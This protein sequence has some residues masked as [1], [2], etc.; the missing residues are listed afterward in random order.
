MCVWRVCGGCVEGECGVSVKWECGGGVW[1]E[2]GG[3]MAPLCMCVCMHCISL[4]STT[5]AV[6][7][8][9]KVVL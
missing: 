9:S 4:T 8:F 6:C 5:R 1:G 2:C 7:Q 3:E